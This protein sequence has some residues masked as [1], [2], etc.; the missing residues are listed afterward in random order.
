MDL[1]IKIKEVKEETRPITLEEKCMILILTDMNYSPKIRDEIEKRMDMLG[2]IRSVGSGNILFRTETIR[3]ATPEEII[4]WHCIGIAKTCG[5][6]EWCTDCPKSKEDFLCYQ[7][8]E[9]RVAEE[10]LKNKEVILELV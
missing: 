10:Y 7:S 6:M 1:K 2:L 8:G 5:V 4:A 9:A 3:D